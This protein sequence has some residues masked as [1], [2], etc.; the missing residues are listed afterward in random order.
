MRFSCPGCGVETVVSRLEEAPDFPFC[1]PRCRMADLDRWFT[2]EY[3]V[4]GET[5]DG[6][7]AGDVIEEP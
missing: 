3:R 5:V 1:S 6:R 2:G 4:P 7:S